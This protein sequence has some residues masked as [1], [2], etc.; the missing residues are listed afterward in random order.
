MEILATL[1]RY[2]FVAALAVEAGVIGF[3]L[4]RLAREKVPSPAKI[5]PQE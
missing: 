5:A 4:L 3:A 1:V 2:G